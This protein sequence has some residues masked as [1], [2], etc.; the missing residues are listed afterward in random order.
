MLF[1]SKEMCT[2][3]GSKLQEKAP[4]NLLAIRWENIVTDFPNLNVK[5]LAAMSSAQYV[6][7]VKKEDKVAIGMAASLLLYNRHNQCSQLQHILG[8]V[9]DHCGITKE[10]CL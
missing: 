7:H 4:E 6:D 2:K 10:V 1:F 5:V 3:M 9:L 8:L